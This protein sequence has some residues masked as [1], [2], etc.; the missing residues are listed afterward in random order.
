MHDAYRVP[1]G[2]EKCD[3]FCY[4]CVNSARHCTA[5]YANFE[6]RNNYCYCIDG[7]YYDSKQYKCVHCPSGCK[8]CSSSSY[9]NSC[10]D[11]MTLYTSSNNKKLC[12]CLDPSYT[13]Y[14]KK[15]HKCHD[16]CLTCNGIS[17]TSCLSCHE[18][19][20]LKSGK[21]LP[22]DPSCENCSD[23]GPNKCTS[24]REGFYFDNGFCKV[25]MTSLFSDSN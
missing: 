8:T 5:C 7:M 6:L 1:N 19:K 11:N 21:C 9:C 25:L 17:N 14:N 23:A 18:N 10:Y 12:K 2:C 20:Y 24:C 16:Q 15:C 4:S 13:I 3:S 22:C